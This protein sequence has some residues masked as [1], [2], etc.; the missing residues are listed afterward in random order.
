MRT[1]QKAEPQRSLAAQ[2][3]RDQITRVAAEVVAEVGY[4]NASTARIAERA[5][6]SKGVITYHFESK[7]EILRSVALN[8]FD[9]CS[10]EI[11]TS[12]AA[13]TT[14]SEQV[15]GW[16]RAELKFFAAHRVEYIA[17]TD[18]MAN[19]RD[20]GFLCAFD[21]EVAAET[22]RLA[23]ILRQ[24]QQQSEFRPFDAEAVAHIILRC[25]DSVLDSWAQDVRAHLNTQIDTL[26]DFI[27]HAVSSGR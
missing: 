18:I 7:D 19:H 17:M 23:K 25:R 14:A 11:E 9:R 5:G 16:I 2:A 3:R 22:H 21:D 15:H 26:L 24:G 20:P 12:I 8:L 6:I 1:A 10:E 13:A 27:D 4:A